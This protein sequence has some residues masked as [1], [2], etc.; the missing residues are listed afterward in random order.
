MA[1]GA[2]PI[3][4]Y[5]QGLTI[6]HAHE[7]AN[8]AHD[9]A[10]KQLDEIHQQHQAAHDI[11]SKDVELRT[12][13]NDMQRAL[14]EQ[15]LKQHLN[16]YYASGAPAPTDS[17]PQPAVPS[18][19]TPGIIGGIPAKPQQAFN[20][21]QEHIA[22]IF[23][24]EAAKMFP[25]GTTIDP[26]LNARLFKLQVAHQT[27]LGDV[28]ATTAGKVAGAQ[29]EAKVPG[30]MAL[31]HQKSLDDREGRLAIAVQQGLDRN[32]AATTMADAR[33]DTAKIMAESRMFVASLAHNNKEIDPNAIEQAYNDNVLG[34]KDLKDFD[35]KT[36]LQIEALH[37][38]IGTVAPDKK[39]LD[40]TLNI[41]PQIEGLM[42]QYKDTI[43]KF[44]RDGT[45][46]S[47]TQAFVS[48]GSGIPGTDLRST[49]DGLRGTGGML[50]TFFD[51][52]N[53]KSDAEILREVK[54]NFDPRNTVQQN[55]DKLN[56]NVQL[57]DKAIGSVMGNMPDKQKHMILQGRNIT[58]FGGGTGKGT[59]TTKGAPT[60]T[61][62]TLGILGQ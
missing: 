24:P 41:V 25:Q 35:P 54:A 31:A 48:G 62:D 5:F 20:L 43:K 40:T 6:K 37:H 23:G 34:L 52:Q 32:Y 19:Q 58:M 59:V 9:L 7:Q 1:T 56:H 27:A 51:K 3:Q 16:D 4:E 53:R 10:L 38:Q 42:A 55:M 17:Q 13:A 47:S 26:E 15:Q 44:S 33:R 57:L 45:Q 61:K 2:S 49:L 11:A 14:V 12:N 46:A 21:P 8:Q 39:Q 36:R 18:E 22:A 60:P 29:E 30:L 28:Q 50:A